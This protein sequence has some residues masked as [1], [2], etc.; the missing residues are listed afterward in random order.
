MTLR[1]SYNEDGLSSY[2]SEIKK[3]PILEEDE[4]HQLA[5]LWQ[6]KGDREA[7]KKLISSHL[8][9]VAKIARGYSGYGI[10]LEDLIAEGNIGVMQAVQHF[11]PTIGYRFSTYAAWWIKAKIQ[12][13]VY[14]TWSIVRL[15]SSK[16]NRK[17]FF[18]LRKMKNALGLDTVDEQH[19]DAIA[20]KL[21]VSKED[22]MT[23]ENRF[24]HQDFSTNTTIGDEEKSSFQDFIQD[25][26]NPLEESVLEKQEFEYRK[27]ILREALATLSERERLIFTE[28]RLQSPPKT[29]KEI[30]Q[31]LQISTERVR[32]I[33]NSVFLKIQKY[34][35]MM[36]WEQTHQ[37]K[38]LKQYRQ[39]SGC[40]LND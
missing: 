13:F 9:L 37:P 10:S 11:D 36:E 19:A 25:N 16:N 33:E 20:K 14:N 27:K 4:E 22:I 18:N 28:Y 1:G 3:F 8:R 35:R 12:E 2:T 32:Q 15:S 30:G 31:E 39:L 38:G 40:A 5:S 7:L 17:T 26:N 34:I 23:L 29:L 6:E 21:A 24:M